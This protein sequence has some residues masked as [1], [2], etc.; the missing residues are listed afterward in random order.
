MRV[1]GLTGGIATGKSTVSRMLAE[2]G[3]PIVDADLIARE[4]VEPGKPA[5]RE[6]VQTF[7]G[8]ILQAD[9][10]LN[11]KLLGKLVFGD[12]ARLQ[13][14]NQITH[15]RI[16]EEIEGRLQALRDK[17]TELA[18]LDAPLLIEANL[19]PLVDEVWVVTCPRELQ[20]KRLQERDNLSVPEAEGRIK[21]QMPLEEKIKYAQRVIDNSR[22]IAH[23]RR[24]VQELLRSYLLCQ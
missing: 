17:G 2:K 22:D 24:Q 16:R 18:V 19:Q 23:T 13:T 9:G 6:I 4:V 20:I 11:R 3:L 12:P 5:Y 7:G 14:L 1:I 10:T 21:A 15:P 8:E